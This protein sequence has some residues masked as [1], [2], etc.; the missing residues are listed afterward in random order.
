MKKLLLVCP[1]LAL[2]LGCG[3]A[4]TNDLD[5]IFPKDKDH[6]V[7]RQGPP[8]ADPVNYSCMHFDSPDP[9]ATPYGGYGGF[10]CLYICI[11]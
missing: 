1:A 5:F 4:P 11:N 2:T 10:P 6:T 7:C 8:P 9:G 3:A